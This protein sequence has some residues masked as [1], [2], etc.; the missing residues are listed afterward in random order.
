[1]VS[2]NSS[3]HPISDIRDWSELNRLVLRPDFQRREV[4]SP[5][6]R[7]MLIDT[8]LRG[9]PMPKV[10]LATRLENGKTYRVVIDG[11]QRLTTILSFL[12]DEFALTSPYSGEHIGK[13][14][15]QIGD[16]QDLILQYKVDFNEA[17]NP[18]ESEVREVYSRVNK[19]TVALNKQ[20]L[21]RADYP[22][23]FLSVAEKVALEPFFE[24]WKVFTVADRRRYGDVEYVSELLAGIIGGIQDR[25]AALDSFYTS[26][27]QWEHQ[28]KSEIIDTFHKVVNELNSI[29]S[30]TSGGKTRFRQ[31]ADL[32]SLF[33]LIGAY[34][35]KGWTILN[36]DISALREDLEILD[37]NIAPE[38]DIP[39]FREY[40]VKCVSQANSSAS[41]KWR[42][43]MLHAF[44]VGAFN[45]GPLDPQAIGILR[46]TKEEV[47][48]D[49]SGMCPDPVF[50]CP[51]CDGEI[52]GDFR[53]CSIGWKSED[54]HFH[55]SNSHWIHTQCVSKMSGWY[56]PSGEPS[57]SDDKNQMGLL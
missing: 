7:V 41:R 45:P 34:V 3:P 26:Y 55:L 56:I 36:K 57:D 27:A 42:Y 1:M 14:F 23:D 21:R 38:S 4:W 15:S 24:T 8:I 37:E 51:Y 13:K 30:Y 33:L 48:I 22:G 39:L 11:Q 40:A 19:Y 12:R 46:Q 25:K 53:D 28:H 49:Q 44:L 52:S 20:E 43:D 10:F 18:S 32:Y 29:L 17:I 6:A 5:A 16:A 47:S 31:K 2:W 9:I 35:R 50:E 54:V